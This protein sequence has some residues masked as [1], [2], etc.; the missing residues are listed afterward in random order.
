METVR[1]NMTPNNEIKTIHC[2]QN[3]GKTRKWGFELYKEDGIID[4]SSIESQMIY[5][6]YKG[7]TEQ[8]LP[9]NSSVPTTAPIIA[10]IQY[11]DALRSEQEFLYR[12]CP[13]N[14][15]GQA[16]I[17]KIKGNT[18]PFNQLVQNGNFADTSSW[19]A[20]TASFSVNNNIGSI[21]ATYRF[22]RL[23]QSVQRYGD[24]KYYVTVEMQMSTVSDQIRA[25]QVNTGNGWLTVDSANNTNWN[26]YSALWTQTGD[27]STADYFRIS[28]DDRSSGW[29]TN[30]VRNCMLFDLTSMGIDSLTTTSEVEAWLSSHIGNLPYF[31]H[32]PGTLL[33]FVGTG[34]KTIGK[35][36]LPLD[37]ATIKSLNTSGTWNDNAYTY[38]TV[39]FNVNLDANGKVTSIVTNG[40]ANTNRALQVMS[41]TLKKG[42]YIVNGCPTGGSS[43]KYRITVT[44]TTYA[45]LA[46]DV[47]SGA[48][49]TLN[50]DTQIYV[51][52]DIR[53]GY[54]ASDV[55]FYPMIRF[56]D[57]NDDTF[58]P[59]TTSTLSL[60][61]LDHFPTGMK[62]AGSIYD[63]LTENKAYTRVGSADLGSLDYTYNSTT[64]RFECDIPSNLKNYGTRLTLLVSAIYEC[65]WHGEAADTNWD[66]VI[67]T[68]ITGKLYI[69]NHAYSN[70]TTFKNAMAG[71]Y[72]FFELSAY[73]ETDITTASLVTEKGETPLYYDD[74]ILK[75]NCL[76]ALSSEAGIFDAKIKL[77]DSETVYSQ[78]IQLH[79][80][81]KP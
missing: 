10:D 67:Y 62:R 18:I 68:G 28:V 54:S 71:Q 30:N 80:E 32:N 11:P 48:S 12:E 47:G 6:C 50:E 55:T 77:A 38:G 59:Y 46:S 60:N 64:M 7:G 15:D 76:T 29:T 37:L 78:K 70:A 40:T 25:I 5:D 17:T 33:L 43:T 53:N 58:E 56:A 57:V 20:T 4:S 22:G 14:K 79:V 65:K 31:A 2:S 49:F 61:V 9:E 34:L 24:H 73:E 35:N 44:T 23:T 36:L 81:R 75:A 51:F 66:M 39:V 3:D 41:A 69:H 27:N 52:C 19:S 26:K 42:S 8:I 21:I 13:S 45:L 72:I 16:K 74:D 1:V 63:E